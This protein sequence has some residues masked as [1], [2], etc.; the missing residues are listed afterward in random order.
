[1]M[2]TIYRNNAPE[3]YTLLDFFDMNGLSIFFSYIIYEK[4]FGD[5]CVRTD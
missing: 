1:M 2:A 5:V 3:E 4:H